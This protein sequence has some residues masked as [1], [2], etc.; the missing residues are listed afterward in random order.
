MPQEWASDMGEWDRGSK[1]ERMGRGEGNREGWGLPRGGRPANLAARQQGAGTAVTLAL[2]PPSPPPIL[3]PPLPPCS[4]APPAQPQERARSLPPPPL[5]PGEQVG[6]QPPPRPPVP[7]RTPVA[8]TPAAGRGGQSPERVA[9]M[10]GGTGGGGG[11]RGGCGGR[12]AKGSFGEVGRGA[13]REREGK[14]GV[15]RWGA[16]PCPAWG[17]AAGAYAVRAGRP[18]SSLPPSPGHPPRPHPP[19]QLVAPPRPSQGVGGGEGVEERG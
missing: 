6:W 18:P 4:H 2:L 10:E 5:R 14:G 13:H 16:N 15:R 17:A 19:T 3:P 7:P 1:K 12:Q 11:G 8:G 9:V